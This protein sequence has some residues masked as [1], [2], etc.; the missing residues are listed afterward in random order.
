MIDGEAV[1][2]GVDGV[3]DFNGLH[4][5]KPDDEIEFYTSSADLSSASW[6]LSQHDCFKRTIS[7][8]RMCPRL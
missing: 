5:R 3:S 7:V 6:H 1:L 4:C 8:I 2:L